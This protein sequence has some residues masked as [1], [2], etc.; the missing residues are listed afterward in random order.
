PGQLT[1]LKFDSVEEGMVFEIEVEVEPKVE[2][3]KYKGLKVEK[4]KVEV[5]EEMIE[6]ALQDLQLRFATAKAADEV[7]EGYV[8]RFDLQAIGEGNVP[9]LGKKLEDAVTRIGSG[10]FGPLEPQ[11]IGMK[12][13]ESRYVEDESPASPDT[14]SDRPPVERYQVTVKSIEEWELPP[15]DDELAI[16][17]GLE[18]V[19]TLDELKAYLRDRIAQQLEQEAEKTLEGRLI[20]ELLKENPFEVPEQMVE[21]YLRVIVEDFKRRYPNEQVDEELIRTKYRPEAIH[22]VRWYLLRQAIIEAENLTVSD[23]EVLEYIDTLNIPRPQKQ[24]LKQHTQHWDEI[25]EQLLHRKVMEVLKSHAQ[26]TEVVSRKESPVPI[27]PGGEGAEA[28]RIITP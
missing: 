15:I 6:Y 24:H 26:I 2:L 23:E 5:T 17:L 14:S 7:K 19:E 16:N 9:V 13:G 8:V 3:K 18:D 28:T 22:M 25:R 10:E 21:N 20:D 12:V 1:D 4:D 27:V 11:M